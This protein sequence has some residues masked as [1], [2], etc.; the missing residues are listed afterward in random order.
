MELRVLEY[1]LMVAREENITKAAALLHITQPTLSRQLAQMEEELGVRLF[2]R[3]KHKITL[4]EEGMLL[5]RRAQEMIELAQKTKKELEH[6]AADLSGK[7]YIGSGETK[8]I[9]FLADWMTEF[10]RLHP[11]VSFDIYSATADQI[12]EQMEK[13]MIDL[14]LLTEPVDVEKYQ[15]IRFPEKTRWGILVRRDSAFAEKEN[16]TAEELCQIPLL[17]PKRDSVQNEIANWF[18]DDFEKLRVIAT[19]NLLNNAAAV[20]ERIQGAVL[21]L[22][23]DNL[24]QNLKFV[25]LE[26]LLTTGTVLIWKRHQFL[27]PLMKCFIE[28]LRNAEKAFYEMKNEYFT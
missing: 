20:A 28:F 6:D 7:I 27:S 16:V 19:Y 10:H 15:Y 12:K 23:Y 9:Y 3:G 8:S 24:Y 21:C 26:P 14:G 11:R 5:K 1:Y 13:G 2:T 17:I 18:Q 22:E 25:P 4:T